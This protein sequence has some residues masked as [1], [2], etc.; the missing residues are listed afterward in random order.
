MDGFLT[1]NDPTGQVRAVLVYHGD[2]AVLERYSGTTAEDYWPM[3]SVS[4]SVMSAL[5]GIALGQGKLRSVDQTL[6]ELLPSYASDMTPEVAA[7]TIQQL[8]THTGGFPNEFDDVQDW[9][10]TKDWI[11]TILTR[12]SAAGPGNGRFVFSHEAVHLLSA[13]LVEATGQSVLDY[14]RTNLFDPLGIP[15]R[16]AYEPTLVLPDHPRHPD[17]DLLE[18]LTNDAGF[19]WP[20]DP[21]GIHEGS[22]S[23]RL[24]PQD[25]AK[26][27]LLYLHEGRLGETQVIPEAW[28]SE[29]TT[30]HKTGISAFF[31][32]RSYGYLWWVNNAHGHPNFIAF[33]HGGETLEVV[34]ELD[35]VVVIITDYDPRESPDENNP[36]YF[37]Q[38]ATDLVSSWIAPHFD[39]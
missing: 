36:I 28:V 24:R 9:W 16:P 33:G 23:L 5:V 20:V 35:L 31:V 17:P 39:T 14:A 10:T 3:R 34:P 25:L 4:K 15:S 19:A 12:R 38:P 22:Y 21:Q 27:G 29:S 37:W 13:I 30:A 6:G 8:L 1:R 7:I 18:T 32:S 11:R 26:I 2:D